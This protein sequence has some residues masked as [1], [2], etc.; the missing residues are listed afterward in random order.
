MNRDE[1]K[2]EKYNPELMDAV[3]VVSIQNNLK[4]ISDFI[5]NSDCD[6]KF[7]NRLIT[8]FTKA[9][10]V[11]KKVTEEL[12]EYVLLY[13]LAVIST[14]LLRL[15]YLFKSK[16]EKIFIMTFGSDIV[17]EDKVQKANSAE[18]DFL[19]WLNDFRS[20]FATEFRMI[21]NLIENKSLSL[22][23]K[24]LQL[25]NNFKEI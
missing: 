15:S 3:L 1:E 5:L 6:P 25:C 9:I 21:A 20:K 22:C 13:Q 10:S 19:E 7:K 8:G 14:S 4:D 12:W 16:D 2:K 24:F 11:S 18:M 17:E 23:N